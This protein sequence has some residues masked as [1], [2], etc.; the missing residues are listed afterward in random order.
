MY[1]PEAP[2]LFHRYAAEGP[3]HVSVKEINFPV[4]AAGEVSP[5]ASLG[6]FVTRGWLHKPT[7][8]PLSE[9]KKLLVTVTSHFDGIY[10]Q[11]GIEYTVLNKDG[12]TWYITSRHVREGEQMED[13]EF[14]IFHDKG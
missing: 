4:A 2:D 11:A 13:K 10:P 1:F 14:V 6:E 5:Q 12:G 9:G 8:I 3:I 7:E